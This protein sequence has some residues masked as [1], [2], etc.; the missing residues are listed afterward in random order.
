VLV[1]REV[2]IPDLPLVGP[3]WRVESVITGDVVSSVPEPVVATLLFT[4][5]GEVFID[6]GCNKGGANVEIGPDRLRFTDLVITEASCEAPFGELETPMLLVLRADE[7]TYSI[8]ADL[9]HLQ[10]GERGL[11]LRGS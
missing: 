1:D 9:L 3:A 2:A 8:D 5:D 10:A 4:A 6:T 11:E 7:V